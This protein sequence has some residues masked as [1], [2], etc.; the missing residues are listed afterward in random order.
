MCGC[1]FQVITE[2]FVEPDLQIRNPGPLHF[3]GLVLRDPLA[4]TTRQFAEFIKFRVVTVADHAAVSCDQRRV[5]G[6]RRIDVGSNFRA[7]I[8]IGFQQLQQVGFSSRQFGFDLR[9]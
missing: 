6:Q 9:Q 4:A 7:Q 8:E 5:V 1:H 2:H 3:P